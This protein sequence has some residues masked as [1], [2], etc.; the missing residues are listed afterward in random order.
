MAGPRLFQWGIQVQLLSSTFVAAHLLVQLLS[1]TFVAAHLLKKDATL[2]QYIRCS[3]FIKKR[4]TVIV[5]GN[6]M[7]NA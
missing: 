6:C 3:P 2:K 7:G 1:S 4:W 5:S